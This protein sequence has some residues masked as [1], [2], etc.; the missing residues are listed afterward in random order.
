MNPRERWERIEKNELAPWATRSGENRG[1]A[2]PERP[3]DIRTAFQVDLD[4]IMQSKSFRRLKH[5][6]QVLFFPEGDHYRTRMTHTL[7]V[8][9]VARTI[10]RALSLNEDL[11][12]AIAMGH[13]L[14]HCAFGHAGESVLDKISKEHGLRGFHHATHGVRVVE[15]IENSGKGLNLCIEVREGIRQHTKG[16]FDFRGTSKLDR[17]SSHEAWVVRLSDLVAY[18][19]HDLDDALR[20]GIISMDGLPKNIKASL[21]DEPGKMSETMIADIIRNSGREGIQMSPRTLDGTEALRKFLY[22]AVYLSPQVRQEFGRVESLLRN[23]YQDLDL[24]PA[25]GR[26]P[27]SLSGIERT[28]AIIDYMAG[29]SDN[30]A[31]H[32]MD[33]H[34]AC[35]AEA[36]W[37]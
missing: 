8:S 1:R 33:E 6:T 36:P 30:F 18:V 22:Q 37:R 16:Q 25:P 35:E 17:P 4:R 7:E 29:M 21:G 14:G 12:E 2:V 5:K 11:T 27:E 31:L 15:H 19:V 34:P 10:A 3:S 26:L 20:A 24:N 23:I 28:Q 9:R 13:D 32:Y